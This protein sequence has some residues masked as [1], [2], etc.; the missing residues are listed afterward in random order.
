MSI[1]LL[2]LQAMHLY[3]SVHIIKYSQYI[4]IFLQIAL[5]STLYLQMMWAL[6]YDPG[7]CSTY[8]EDN[9]GAVVHKI[10]GKVKSIRQFGKYERENMKKRANDGDG[11]VPI[12]VFLVASV[13]KE[14]STK[15]LQEARGI[16]DIIRV[17]S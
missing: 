5:N 16:D 13:L 7:I 6:E 8:E 15:L 2:A 10:E 4:L 11:P 1:P 17:R 3:G 14:N 12:S 9:T